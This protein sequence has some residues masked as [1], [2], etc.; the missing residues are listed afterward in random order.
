MEAAL[1]LA[2]HSDLGANHAGYIL[3]QL[4]E[5]FNGCEPRQDGQQGITSL[6]RPVAT[7]T[8]RERPRDSPEP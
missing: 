4:A 2:I 1:S 7:S 5:L 8:K 3:E 6:M